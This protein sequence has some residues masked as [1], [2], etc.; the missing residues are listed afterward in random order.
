MA[1]SAACRLRDR[2]LRSLGAEAF[3]AW[4]YS[5]AATKGCGPKPGTLPALYRLAN[6]A[7]RSKT[8]ECRGPIRSRARQKR[9]GFRALTRARSFPRFPR[10]H[11][12]YDCLIERLF[13]CGFLNPWSVGLSDFQNEDE[14]EREGEFQSDL[15]DKKSVGRR[16][17]T[18]A[19]ASFW[20]RL[21]AALRF[22]GITM[23]P[24][25]LDRRVPRRM[26]FPS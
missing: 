1:S 16:G 7:S 24:R 10:A 25:L 13:Y 14:Y 23:A 21:G 4:D 11:R 8:G 9:N 15:H 12:R 3:A 26:R 2:S 5:A 22:S 18:L 6:M 17:L 19:G 20:H